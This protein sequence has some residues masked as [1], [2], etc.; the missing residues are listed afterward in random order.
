M[1][2]VRCKR[3]GETMPIRIVVADDHALFAQA[4]AQLLAQRYVVVEVVTDGRALQAS[5]RKHQPDVVV[6]DVTMPLMSGL[7]SIRSLRKENH[8]PKV[9]FLTMHTDT[10]LAR[11]C[12]NC[13]GAAFVTK[14][15]S[16]D[17]LIAAIETV[18]SNQ[19]YLSPGVAAELI[20]VLRE[21]PSSGPEFDQLTS[22]QREILQLF[23][24]GKTMKEIASVTNLST[25]TVE[26][27]KYRMMR[28]LRV[29]RSAELVQHAVRLKLVV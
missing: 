25:R 16:Y 21:P 19:L 18:M 24:E 28:M 11:E 26:W 23:A 10:E 14:E 20:D 8:V 2:E 9:V 7:E 5:V 1:M 12:F 29:R 27:H 17:E 3:M 13:G 22:R 6:V 4:V 15:S